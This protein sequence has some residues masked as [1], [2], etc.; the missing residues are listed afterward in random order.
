MNT[1]QEI[2]TNKALEGWA[3]DFGLGHAVFS[4]GLV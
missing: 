1:K 4:S 3:Y 2:K